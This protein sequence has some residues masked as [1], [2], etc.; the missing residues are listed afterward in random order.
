MRIYHYLI[1]K[2]SHIFLYKISELNSA[3]RSEK[4]E[5][6]STDSRME[7]A[8]NHSNVME[9]LTTRFKEINSKV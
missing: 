3:A 2:Y 9:L 4:F 6:P 5:T 7:I 8:S 1:P